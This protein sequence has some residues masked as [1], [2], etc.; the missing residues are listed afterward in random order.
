MRDERER[1][2]RPADD[3]EDGPGGPT[4]DRSSFL[5][6]LV[7]GA[8]VGAGI[9]PHHISG[10]LGIVR[11]YAARVGEGPFP[12]EMLDDEEP[13]AYLIRERGNEYGSVTRRPRR[14]GW[15][16]A[17]AT[18]YAAELNG[19]DSIALTKL[20]VLDEL[21]EIKV[22]TGYKIG[23]AY[24][25]TFPAVENDLRSIQ[26]VYETLEGW[27]E[28][29]VGITNVEDLPAKARNYVR[30]LSDSIGVEIGLISTGPERGQTIILKDSVME[31]WFRG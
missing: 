26:P 15:F 28:S 21:E 8:A 17:V 27:G 13:I 10:V 18:R 23:D 24:V 25:D 4:R 31:N 19:F 11:T 12:T 20:D 30:F 22:C 6:G 7:I 14:C 2:P 9:P 5:T 29:T 3:D 1:R 16:D